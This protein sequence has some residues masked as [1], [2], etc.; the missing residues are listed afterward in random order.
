MKKLDEFATTVRDE[1]KSRTPEDT[2]DLVNSINKTEQIFTGTK[3]L[4]QVKSTA[5][6]EYVGY[7]EY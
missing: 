1:V 5:E 2:K 6:L 3:I 7:V 4:Q